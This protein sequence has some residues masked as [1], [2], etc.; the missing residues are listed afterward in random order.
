MIRKGDVH[1]GSLLIWTYLAITPFHVTDVGI[2]SLVMTECE[3]IM[4]ACSSAILSPVCEQKHLL[5]ENNSRPGNVYL[6][7]FIAGQPAVL[8]VTITSP[9]QASLISDEA[10][11]CGFALTLAEDRKVAHYYQTCGDMCIFF[12]PLALETFGGLSETTLKTLKRIALLSDNRS[13]KPSG[14]SG[15]F[16]RLSSCI[17]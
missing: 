8:D 17:N 1:I 16:N 12:I 9:L 5:P 3:T 10:R 13:F 11:T 4:A 14:L 15:A 7:S 2:L 6:P